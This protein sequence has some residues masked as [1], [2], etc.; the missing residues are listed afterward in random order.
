MENIVGA[1]GI[2]SRNTTVPPDMP[3]SASAELEPIPYDLDK[4]KELM[5]ASSIAGRILDDAQRH[6]AE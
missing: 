5:A 3:G 1:T 2:Q 4:A 6:R